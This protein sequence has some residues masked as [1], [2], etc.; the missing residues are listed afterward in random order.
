MAVAFD[1]KCT[2]F[3]PFNAATVTATNQVTVGAGANR[4]LIVGLF[5]DKATVP[6]GLTVTWNGT[7]TLTQIV[8]ATASQSV[9]TVS[10]VVL[11]GLVN[12]TSGKK[13]LVASWTGTQQGYIGSISFTGADQ[14]GGA[15]TFPN[16]AGNS[17]SRAA[18][19][20]AT[21]TITSNANNAIVAFHT[22]NN[23]QLFSHIS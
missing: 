10:S 14:T 8:G 11:F 13:S 23:T 12:P 19:A 3:D 4:V 18:T 1:A 5:F 6:A 17:N 22:D 7:E 2:A 21:V 15:T 9:A 20:T 16:G